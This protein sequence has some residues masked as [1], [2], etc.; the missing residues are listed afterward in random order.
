M[1][2]DP[3]DARL[4]AGTDRGGVL[5][6][7]NQ[8][9]VLDATDVHTALALCRLGGETR[10]LV[11]LAAALAVRAPRA[12]H[13]LADLATVA[14][15]VITDAPGDAGDGGHL[16]Q[17]PW[18]DVATWLG[19][20]AG[21]PLVTV[22]PALGAVP[23][24]PLPG[25]GPLPGTP[26]DG[27]RDGPRPLHLAG[28]A[29]YLDRYWQDEEA[30][31][32]ALTTR[33]ASEGPA[34]DEAA[35]KDGLARLFGPDDGDLQARAAA[36]S[37]RQRLSV[38]AGGP[39][40]GKTTTVARLL[41][42][43]D[44]QAAA[45]G[46]RPPLVALAAPTGKAAARMAEAVHA[47]AERLDVEGAV[48]Q[49]LA[50][51]TASTVH[52]L[53]GRRPGSAGRPRHDEHNL[54]PHD[55]VVV[56]ETSMLS[57]PLMAR[58]L[59]AVRRDARLVVIGDHQQLASVEAGA[60]LG[61]V[62]GP[63]AEPAP[64]PPGGCGE[65][66]P[67]ARCITVLTANHRFSGPLADLADAVRAGDEERAVELLRSGR[68]DEPAA[69]APLLWLEVDVTAG[70]RG[71]S[72]LAQL[73]QLSPVREALARFWDEVL[74]AAS[75]G[76]G[77]AALSALGRLRLLCAHRDG[78]AG[79]STWS[80]VAQQWLG[81]GREGQESHALSPWYL[82]RPVIVTA[83]DYSLGLFNGDTGVAVRRPDGNLS[84]VFERAGVVKG[85]SP[86]RLAAV[87]TAF[88]LT[89]HR[90]QGSELDEVV[91][92][93]PGPASRVLTRELL[94]TAVTRAKRRV[95]VVG[96]EEPLRSAINRRVARASG[97]TARLWQRPAANQLADR[98]AP[99]SA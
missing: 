7:F 56:D 98:G 1:L 97:L 45:M 92:L 89:A 48:R 86:A 9:G 41:A 64:A 94:Y 84:V 44:Q 67:V 61:D 55:V 76:D 54:L 24:G 15:T 4:V 3:F 77:R 91:V 57:L 34:V 10:P 85:F 93:L 27:A 13:V 16:S 80:S 78:P 38:I 63:A 35:L 62:V 17:L 14:A 90:A 70:A 52:R 75:A 19:E 51:L 33:A 87:E 23:A 39:G 12:G 49:R 81:A 30:V 42:L 21:S 22:Q 50:A 96:G 26:E 43:L 18:P 40:T 36:I 69:T 32:A 71:P 2:V 66:A 73:P 60:V 83:N 37:V 25:R 79:A 46:Q 53:L 8:A 59:A 28:T 29:L 88:A 95:V 6:A 82:G 58:L 20:V 72:Q 5:A 31:A 47:E 99:G 65:A 74:A 11:Q 68:R